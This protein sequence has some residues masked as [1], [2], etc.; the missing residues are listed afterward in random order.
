M[1]GQSTHRGKRG[2]LLTTALGTS[3]D[4]ETGVFAPEATAGPNAAGLVPEG[5]P[6]GGEV[7]VPGGDAEQDGII[8]KEF[9]GLGNR[10]IWLR[11][12]VHLAQDIR[13]EGLGDPG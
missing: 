9:I 13:A 8:V 1:V 11:R 5:L 3:G 6:L 10:V 12:G 2:R 4:E 7:A